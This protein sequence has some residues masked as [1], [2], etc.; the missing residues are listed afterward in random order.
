MGRSTMD[1]IEELENEAQKFRQEAVATGRQS[2]VALAVG[3]ENRTVFVYDSEG[4]KQSKLAKLNE[5]V[6]GGGEPIGMIAIIYARREGTFYSR[7]L[8]EYAHEPQLHSY[9]KKLITTCAQLIGV[10]NLSPGEWLP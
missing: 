3:F 6:A 7:L 5:A 2:L 9:L 4:D 8:A 1:L 10:S